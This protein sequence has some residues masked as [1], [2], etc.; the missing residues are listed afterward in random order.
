MEDVKILSSSENSRRPSEI[1]TNVVLL[2][3][4]GGRIKR[5]T[6]NAT[7]ENKNNDTSDTAGQ[8]NV[9]TD[10]VQHQNDNKVYSSE[11]GGDGGSPKGQISLQNVDINEEEFNKRRKDHESDFD[12]TYNVGFVERLL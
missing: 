7:S 12:H 1:R 11:D 10:V 2:S 5:D 4:S 3:D 8:Q 9:N 6:S